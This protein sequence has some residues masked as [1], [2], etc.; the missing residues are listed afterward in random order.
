[1]HAVFCTGLVPQT[2][3]YRCSRGTANPIARYQN[4]I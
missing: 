3:S 4:L 2:C 1:M